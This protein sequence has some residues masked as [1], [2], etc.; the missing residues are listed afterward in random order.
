MPNWTK[1]QL[2]A[3]NTKGGKI[4]VSAAAGSGKTAVLSQRVINLVMQEV[5][6]D[7]LLIVTFT[8]LAS[9]EM[10][11]RIRQKLQEAY[12]K[13]PSNEHLQK[14]L[15]LIP[16]AKITTMDSFYNELVKDNFEKLK[17]NKDFEVLSSEEEA[18]LKNMVLNKVLD[19][20]LK[21]EQ[22]IYV[23]NK[24]SISNLDLLKNY[25]MKIHSFL[26]T[27][28]YPDKAI[29][30]MINNYDANSSFY[31]DLILEQIREK[32][33]SYD[34]LY[35]E[36]ISELYDYDDG[37]D[38]VLEQALKER[39]YLSSII[40]IDN[41]NELSKRLKTI[42]FDS[43]KTPRGHKDDEVIVK[44][45]I[46]RD[47][48]KKDIKKNY[49]ELMFIDDDTFKKEQEDTKKLI[50]C[51]FNIEKSFSYF[52]LLEKK[53]QN[54]FSF[55]DVAHFVIELL[56]KDG[57]KTDTAKT[58]SSSFKEIL[59]DEY[60][61][62]NNLQNIIF[63]A[64]SNDNKNLFIVGD[65]KQ[66]IYRFR[67]ACPEIFN[68]DK[69]QATKDGFPRLIN[70]SKNF[71]SRKEVLDFCNF[72]FENTMSLSFGQVDYN[73][74]EQLY[75]G[76]NFEETNDMNPE[77]I[78]IDGE[79]KNEETGE[80]EENLTNVQK[81]AKVVADKIESL[82]KGNYKVYDA[83]KN[84]RRNITPSD[85][86][87]LLR[88]LNDSEVFASAIRKKGIS[89]YMESALQYLD[90]YEVKLIINFLKIIDNPH[91]DVA[92]MSVLNSSLVNANLDDIVSLRKNN[93]NVS[94]YDNLKDSFNGD[95]F[96]K[97]KS[98]R[99]YSFTH[100]LSETLCKMYKD[101]NVISILSS[102]QMGEARY[103]NLTHMINHAISYESKG[104]KS[105]HE[106]ICYL[107][108]IMLNKQTL[109]GV[110]PLSSKDNVLIT[111]I[112]KS[113]GLEYPVVFLSECGKN[114]N[115]KDIKEDVMLNEE[116]GFV[117]NLKDNEH[118]LKYESVPVMAFKRHEKTM[119]L[120][121]ELRILYVALT[122]AKEKLIITGYTNNL[123]KLV[124]NASSKIGEKQVSSLLYLNEAK[125]YLDILLVAL[126]RHPLLGKLRS[127]SM[128]SSKTF[129]TESKVNLEIINAKDINESI[130]YS[131][132]NAQKKK[133]DHDWFMKVRG[134]KYDETM[135]NVPVYL[136]VSEIKKEKN[137]L[138]KPNFLD[139]GIANTKIG[140]LY[141]LILELLPIKRYNM[142]EL[143]EE[144]NKM[145]LDKKITKEELS[146]IKAENVFSYLTTS[147][148]EDV[149]HSDLVCKE[150]ALDFEIPIEYY[151]KSLKSDNILTSGVIDLLFIKDDIYTIVD[152]KTDNVTSMEE[153]KQRY[154]KQLDL[155]EVGIKKKMH[156]KKIRKFIYSIK[157]NKFIEV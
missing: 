77:V 128:V 131:K 147:I 53:R 43:L 44:Y 110:N 41:F 144:L 151:D 121:E 4:I 135:S 107:E 143:K 1:D 100:D 54:K 87:I 136:S 58:I 95:F 5:N 119:M 148:Y 62:T 30:K 36:L 116:L 13:D 99:N 111:T 156:A 112:H 80:D 117:C 83:N 79:E 46:I 94:L 61:D 108:D 21:D 103:K 49:Y 130:I 141:H 120:S 125:N 126:L 109:E 84:L 98:L 101:F 34:N 20:F 45:K 39:N 48:F 149:L 18:V 154:K 2:L 3:I 74:D 91:D 57:K 139:G 115:F 122:R 71:R 17:I 133:F 145:V 28:P 81:E 86:V 27:L 127:L 55:S 15:S 150:F 7:E 32:M 82:L 11:V 50:T 14:Q 63:S 157:L 140:S 129:L 78:I 64:I 40:K 31:K 105:L 90:N 70:L 104:N 60:Q 26:Q 25:V 76:A 67:S 37:F 96:D 29:T 72:V 114:F 93:F 42:N 38:K 9:Q 19:K 56:I 113:K 118:K 123:S 155:Y 138:V 153:L 16:L 52:L 75:L 132:E 102:Q 35:D 142:L 92:L 59:I 106:F 124:T 6:V 10:M 47:D 89:V 23:L 88:S 134:F 33:T 137:Y 73:K 97:L 146:L 152:Y 66:S 8:K 69:K 51:L 12:L 85:I 65:V 68:N 22:Y 24:F